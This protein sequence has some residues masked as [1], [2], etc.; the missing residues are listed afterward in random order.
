MLYRAEYVVPVSHSPIKD[1]AVLVRNGKI[2]EV[3]S[4]DALIYRYPEEPVKDFGISALLPGFISTHIHLED[5]AMRGLVSDVPYIEWISAMHDFGQR[6]TE[7]D[8]LYS[9]MGGCME[10][11]KRGITCVA[12]PCGSTAPVKALAAAGMRAVALRE[13]GALDR[14]QVDAAVGQAQQDIEDWYGFID[15]ALIQPGLASASMYKCHPEVF[16]RIAKIARAE[17]MS[18]SMHMAGSREIHNFVK[19]GTSPFR[20]REGEQIY[21][22]VVSEWMPTGVSCVQ[23]AANWGAF[24]VPNMIARH[25]VFVD[26]N[27]MRILKDYDVAV[28]VCPRYSAQL[29]MGI[30]RGLDFLRLGIRVGLGNDSPAATDSIDLFEE[31]RLGMLLGR[32]LGRSQFI[33][34]SEMLRLVTIDAARVLGLE[35]KIGSLEVGKQADMIAVDI[36]NSRRA[37]AAKPEVYLVNNCGGPDIVMTMVNGEILYENKQWRVGFDTNEAVSHVVDIRKGLRA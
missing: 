2:V 34:C 31:M 24:D 10:A 21:S 28:S 20:T 13:V 3:D 26:A 19:Y 37:P 36:T 25:C 5:Y 35:K 32:G 12:N 4:F 27:D 33:T 15:P 7:D 6:M 1:G 22:T 29:G 14:S 17:N 11:L 23:Y 30:S 18:V 16:A 9:S 8:Q